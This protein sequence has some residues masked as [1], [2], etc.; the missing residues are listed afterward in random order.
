MAIRYP[1]SY[2]PKT[3]MANEWLPEGDELKNELDPF[4]PFGEQQFDQTQME[5]PSFTP[6]VQP[7]YNP[8]IPIQNDGSGKDLARNDRLYAYDEGRR[9][10]NDVDD[11]LNNERALRN[12]YRETADASYDPLLAGQGGYTEDERN[13]IMQGEHLA[14]LQMTNDEFGQSYLGDDEGRAIQGDPNSQRQWFDPQSNWDIQHSG[15]RNIRGAYGHLQDRLDSAVNPAALRMREGW[16]EEYRGEADLGGENIRGALSGPDTEIS[17]EFLRDYQ[18]SPEEQ[19]AMIGAA[20]KSIGNKWRGQATDLERRASAAGMN[21]AGTAAIKSRYLRNAASDSADAA[22]RA[23]VATDEAAAQR[24]ATG[25][26]MRVGYGQRIAGMRSNAERDIMD[27]RM[28]A[29]LT[30]EEMRLGTERDISG[31]MMEGA[32]AGQM[33]RLQAEMS[34]AN[35][36]AGLQRYLQG[37]GMG[38]ERDIDQT[39]SD[40]AAFMGTNR[41]DAARYNSGQRYGRGLAVNDRVSGRNQ[42]QADARRAD[43]QEGRGYVVGQS[44][45]GSRNEQAAWDRSLGTYNARIGAG[46]RG[47][48]GV[49]QGEGQPS[50]WERVLGMGLGA[51]SGI[52]GAAFGGG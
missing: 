20:S 36:A 5:P 50:T 30:D 6:A 23:R 44:N 1:R 14:G 45:L 2:V 40:R 49:L 42:G 21:P 12:R 18:M 8:T 48:Q 3:V 10:Q 16:G 9:L 28:N 33:P 17:S 19:E 52:A 39:Q 15:E 22:L 35:N 13:E 7:T 32:I 41:Q 25:E 11:S 34:L 26:D 24:M 38:M 4:D 31:R 51:A 47:T 46:Q 27:A 29:L 37:T 43:S